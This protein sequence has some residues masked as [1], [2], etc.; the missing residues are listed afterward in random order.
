MIVVM[1]LPRLWGLLADLVPVNL[2]SPVRR[3][4][5]WTLDF[6]AL[7][8]NHMPMIHAD[9][10]NVMQTFLESCSVHLPSRED[11]E[12]TFHIVRR[13]RFGDDVYS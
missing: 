1:S 6:E 2:A 9:H 5:S 10:L 12:K 13:H 8:Q 4:L 7:V 11:I 3:H